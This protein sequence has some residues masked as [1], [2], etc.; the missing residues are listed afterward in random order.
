MARLKKWSVPLSAAPVR[1][2]SS[3]LADRRARPIYHF[4]HHEPKAPT[5]KLKIQRQGEVHGCFCTDRLTTDKEV[6]LE[7]VGTTGP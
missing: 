4:N 6:L 3:R 7:C 5:A 2:H 1:E